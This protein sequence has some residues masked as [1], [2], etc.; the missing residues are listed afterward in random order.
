MSFHID[1]ARESSARDEESAALLVR[2]VALAGLIILFICLVGAVR[3]PTV[4]PIWLTYKQVFMQDIWLVV[5]MLG[6]GGL[7]WIAS[8]LH[9]RSL[10]I[11]RLA[12]IFMGI[13]IVIVCYTGRYLV[14]QGYDLTRDEQM[15][16]FDAWIFSRGHLVWPIAPEWHSEAQALNL[17][18]MYPVEHPQAWVSSYLPGNALLHALV[19]RVVDPA[20]TAPLLTGMSLLLICSVARRLWPADRDVITVILIL[21]VLSGQVLL[22]GMTTYA[23]AGHLIF[24]LAWLWLFLINRRHT[25]LLALAIGFFATGLHQPIFH[26]LF[27]APFLLFLLVD[28]NWVRFSFFLLGYVVVGIF[29]LSWPSHVATMISGTPSVSPQV[30]A[31]YLSRLHQLLANNSHALTIM[32]ANLLRFLTWQHIAVLPLML[33]SW[34]AVRRGGL[35]AALALGLFLPVLVLTVVL[36]WQGNGFGYRYLHPVL[37]NALLLAGFGWRELES[38]HA[39]LRPALVGASCATLLVMVPSWIALSYSRYAPYALASRTIDASGA[40]YAVL[41][42]SNGISYGSVVFN[43]PDLGNRPVRLTAER[44]REP[45]ALAKLICRPGVKVALATDEFFQPGA[46]YFRIPWQA[47]ATERLPALRAPFEQA[48]CEILLLR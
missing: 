24:N 34:P 5:A 14:L 25:D 27:V 1:T 44:I 11:S 13:A 26:P 28:R 30:G 3:V 47:R 37:G 36:P 35:P 33:A 48:G 43:R 46:A 39:R 2:K 20:W 40:D 17:M 6:A 22:N 15:V 41:Q 4:W 42:M 16:T 7:T 29:W 45:A 31:D 23:M 10:E 21:F 38:L 18:F 19:G 8:R 32:S 9:L 12:V